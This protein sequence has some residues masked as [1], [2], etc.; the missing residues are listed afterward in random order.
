MVQAYITYNYIKAAPY[1]QPS[2]R[3]LWYANRLYETWCAYVKP[4]RLVEYVNHL[5]YSILAILFSSHTSCRSQLP[6]AMPDAPDQ[7][8]K[9]LDQVRQTC[10]RRR[11]S[12][13]REKTYVR[14]AERF[15]CVHD[16]THPRPSSRTTSGPS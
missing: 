13:H 14:W 12:Y 3:N 1:A 15:A 5:T 8:P 2:S 4:V 16:T 9:L 10:R 11:Y 6:V 7:S